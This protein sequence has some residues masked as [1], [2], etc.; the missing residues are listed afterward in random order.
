MEGQEQPPPPQGDEG[1]SSGLEEALQRGLNMVEELTQKK[2]SSQGQEDI[3]G[4]R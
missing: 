2:E 1:D 3:S 4:I